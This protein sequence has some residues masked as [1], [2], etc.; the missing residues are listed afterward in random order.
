MSE[1]VDYKA[2]TL[3]GAIFSG[4]GTGLTV[5]PTSFQSNVQTFQGP[6]TP[7]ATGGTFTWLKPMGGSM[8]LV[9]CWGGGAGGAASAAAAA[10]GTLQISC[11]FQ[12]YH[13]PWRF[14]LVRVADLLLVVVTL[15]SVPTEQER[16]L[17]MVAVPLPLAVSSAVAVAEWQALE[18]GRPPGHKEGVLRPVAQD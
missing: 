5:G 7:V 9:E 13:Q 4:V 3:T 15:Y 10:V 1:T 14:Q 8:V 16:L 6:G 18:W 11:L 2:A 17:D 12:P